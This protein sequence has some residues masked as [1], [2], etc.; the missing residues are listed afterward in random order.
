VYVKL[1]KNCGGCVANEGADGRSIPSPVRVGYGH[2]KKNFHLV[3]WNVEL[4]CILDSGAWR[5]YSNCNH[6]VT[7]VYIF[8]GAINYGPGGRGPLNALHNVHDLLLRH[9]VMGTRQLKH[10]QCASAARSSNNTINMIPTHYQCVTSIN[11]ST[12]AILIL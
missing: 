12:R 10:K 8:R 6:D 1:V 7:S 9:W 4:L 11:V 5:W 2:Q 3:L